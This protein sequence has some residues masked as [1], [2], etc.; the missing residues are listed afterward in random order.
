MLYFFAPS[1]EAGAIYG[2]PAS[3]HWAGRKAKAAI[4]D[5]RERIARALG[6]ESE[7]EL[8][9]T[10]SGTEATNAAL[11]GAFFY[12]TQSGKK[13][14][15]ITSL[16]EHEATLETA[17]FIESLGGQAHYLEVDQSGQ[18]LAGQL[19]TRLGELAADKA[20]S[21][22]V[23]LMAANNETGVLFPIR[24]IGELCERFGALFHV[25]AIQAVGKTEAPFSVAD[26]LAHLA[27]F[28]AHKIG[29]PKGV[30]ALYVRRGLKLVS[31]LHGGAQERRRRAGTQNVAGIVGFGTAAE[32]L[33]EES[34]ARTRELRDHLES[35]LAQ[36]LPGVKIQG[37][38][39]PRLVNTANL[40]FSGVRGDS[41]LMSLD[42]E[43]IAVSTGSACASGTVNPSH[44]LLAMGF[45]K[46]DAT[47]A[48][49]VSLGSQ[50]THAEVER[51]LGVLPAL[52]ERILSK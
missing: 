20:N 1:E 3:I 2:N 6:V 46:E 33:D 43:G 47:S 9:F 23:S 15:L 27:S 5:A 17:R 38:A 26:S 50:N 16:V 8:V 40:L 28:S 12:A 10:G 30:G 44:V 21:V 49:R 7:E 52:V 35:V 24:A 13:F 19:E 32:L 25:D 14:H 48:I 31:L 41:L 22:L 11:K 37:K 4:D 29:G 34:P 39:A 36:R 45:S 42:L 18:L 51:F